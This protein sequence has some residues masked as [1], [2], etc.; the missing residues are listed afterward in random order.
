MRMNPRSIEKAMKRMGMQATPIEAESVVIKTSEKEILISNPQVTRVN[1]MGMDTFWMKEAFGDRLVFHGA[2]DV[3][4][5]L[6]FSTPEEVRYD[7]AKR[8]WDLGR[9]GGYILS[10][11]HDIG[12]DVPP[13]N[14]VAMFEAAHAYGRY[15]LQMEG[16]LRPEDLHPTARSPSPSDK[17]PARRRKRRR[18]R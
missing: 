2:I 5:M 11:C 7:V 12:E 6:P 9:G 3:Q 13:E 15:P 8:I 18:A 14:V 17:P 1:A 16:V 10:T 4:Q